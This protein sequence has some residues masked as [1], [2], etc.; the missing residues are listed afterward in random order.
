MKKF[1]HTGHKQN[2]CVTIISPLNLKSYSK[3]EIFLLGD[4]FMQTYVTVFDRENDRIGFAPAIHPETAG[5]VIFDSD[6][7]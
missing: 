7:E 2:D 4:T 3:K 1:K 6:D 5:E